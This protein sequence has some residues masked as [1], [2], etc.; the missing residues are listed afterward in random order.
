MLS[1]STINKLST[2][3]EDLFTVSAWKVRHIKTQVMHLVEII[4]YPRILA[5]Y[6]KVGAT[7]RRRVCT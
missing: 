1:H 3:H 4:R 7:L 6:K 2:M 5:I